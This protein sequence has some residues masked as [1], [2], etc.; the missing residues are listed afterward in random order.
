MNI[1]NTKAYVQL[2][3]G[4]KPNEVLG[5]RL[6]TMLAKRLIPHYRFT[7]PELAWFRDARLTDTLTRF[8]ENHGFNAHRKHALQQLLRLIDGVAGD[9]VECG[10]YKGCSSFIMLSANGKSSFARTHHIFDSFEGLSGPTDKDGQYWTANDLAV[11]EQMVRQ[12]LHE[13]ENAILYRGWI[14]DRFAE[15]A[16]Q[17]FSFVHV[18]VDL[19]QPTLESIMFFYDRINPGGIFV[20]DDFG[21]L[22]CPG[23][24]AAVKEFL[25]A[26][27]EKMI[28]LAGGGGF[29]IKGCVT[30]GE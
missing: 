14:P 9:T 1:S 27:P 4:L 20:C 17:R 23:A 13:F 29:F 21:F 3:L 30:A 25:R 11:T 12:N 28:S 24:T 8:G 22:T 16:N 10:V 6:V 2:L 26:K 15:V 5:F 7:W 18:D 19:Y